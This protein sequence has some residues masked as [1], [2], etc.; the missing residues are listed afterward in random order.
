MLITLSFKKRL[1]VEQFQVHYLENKKI[2]C[3]EKLV[4]EQGHPL[5]QQFP[6]KS[7]KFSENANCR[8]KLLFISRGLKLGHFGNFDAF[9]P[10]LAFFVIAHNMKIFYTI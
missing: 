10:F 9:F 3:M 8:T 5:Q 1:I 6:Y 4:G 7:Y 2:N